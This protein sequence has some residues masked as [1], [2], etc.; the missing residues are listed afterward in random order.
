[1]IT[2]GAILVQLH[3]LFDHNDIKLTKWVYDD[4][5]DSS[6]GFNLNEYNSKFAIGLLPNTL[7]ENEI[8]LED[9]DFSEYGS[10]RARL[11]TWGRNF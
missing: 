3:N 5:L 1:M 4:Y 8:L 6:F 11:I 10:L 2:S 9:N 7:D